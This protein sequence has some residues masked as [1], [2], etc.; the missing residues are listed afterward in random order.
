[1]VKISEIDLKLWDK[2]Q[3]KFAPYPDVNILVGVNGSGK[4]TLLSEITNNILKNKKEEN[5]WIYIPSVDNLEMRDKRKR[6]TALSQDLDAYIYDMKTGPSLM[7]YR[8]SML[9]ASPAL[10]SRVKE[11]INH[12]CHIVNT[13]FQTTG[14]HIEIEGNKFII[15]SDGKSL[16]T[17]DLSSGEK[18][19]LLILLRVFLLNEKESVVLIDEPENSL[20]ISWQYRL[21]DMLVSLNPNAQFFIT[22]HSPSIF[23]DG[24]GNRIVY[25]EDITTAIK[26]SV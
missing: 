12:F 2:S 17:N 21:I 25:M 3:V 15:D 23:S 13:L 18:Q 22:T 6:Q 24:W 8:M 4:T 14:K 20:D 26:P 10:Q 19:I 5:S 1:M 16:S 9:D 11:R 7:F